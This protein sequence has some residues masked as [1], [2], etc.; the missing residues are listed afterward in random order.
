MIE[1]RF[2][3]S[4]ED[5]RPDAAQGTGGMAVIR[6]TEHNHLSRALR[7]REGAEVAVFD[8]AG[9]GYHGR[10]DSIGRE[11][12]RV[13]LTS[14][15]T[16][17]V[18]PAFSLTLAQG[19]PHHEKMEWI[20]QKTTELGIS[21]IVPV[22]SRNSVLRP[23]DGDWRRLERWR[24]TA[25]EAAR[26]SGRLVVPDVAAPAS[27]SE[28]MEEWASGGAARQGFL[29]STAP[30]RPAVP[31]TTGLRIHPATHEGLVVVGPEGGLAED[32]EAEGLRRGLFPL[33]LGPRILRA[34]TAGVVAVALVMFLAGD[35]A[36]K[37]VAGS[38]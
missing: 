1:R 27:W 16:R 17:D 3:V 24:R 2:L 32:E 31:G 18:E 9:R 29:L 37:I 25:A 6:G 5:L 4:P 13:A 33:G 15:D 36:P 20:I 28:A 14:P 10:V 35:L 7:L 26:Q 23:K 38:R 19:I 11:E 8:G 34:E 22:V 30:A 12:T 21:R